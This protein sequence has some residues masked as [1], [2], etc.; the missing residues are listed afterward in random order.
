[1]FLI[2]WPGG[3]RWAISP[4]ARS[5]FLILDLKI[6]AQMLEI[7]I[8][9]TKKSHSSFGAFKKFYSRVFSAGNNPMVE[10]LQSKS[11]LTQQ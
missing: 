7:L 11:Y 5:T 10:N 8:A 1:M 4:N 9:A 3:V 2:S 6:R